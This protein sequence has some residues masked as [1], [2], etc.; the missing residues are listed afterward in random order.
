MESWSSGRSGEDLS[1]KRENQAAASR[2][3]IDEI[4]QVLSK[5]SKDDDLHDYLKSDATV[6][7]AL[8]HWTGVQRLGPEES[9]QVRSD[10]LID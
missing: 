9:Q 7:K 2:K 5:L 3:G 1:V 10:S 6:K 4:N 8:K